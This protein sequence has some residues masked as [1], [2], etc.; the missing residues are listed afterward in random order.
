[1]G[2]FW[3]GVGTLLVGIV[4]GV[5]VV[6]AEDRVKSFFAERPVHAEFYPSAWH[7][8]P[9]SRTSDPV[10]LLSGSGLGRY[11]IEKLT[12]GTDPNF[13]KIEIINRGHK[14]A[15]NLRFQ[16]M[17]QRDDGSPLLPPHLLVVSG[18]TNPTR[19][20]YDEATDVPVPD[21][22]PGASAT[23]YMWR[24][25]DLSSEYLMD[26]FR[27]ISETGVVPTTLHRYDDQESRRYN[28]PGWYKLID[29]G[30]PFLLVGL[31]ILLSVVGI[32]GAA[33]YEAY[34][35]KLLSDDLL[36]LGEKVRYD[37]DPKKFEI[38]TNLLK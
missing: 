12:T 33:L 26:D 9:N 31:L 34:T 13:A 17:D 28:E 29:E 4:I 21:I 10:L 15:T 5:V 7:P 6:A 36:Y 1:M 11:E 19:A 37:A 20:F 22:E 23:L 25:T 8:Y 24:I 38:D 27:I 16:N 2:W 14:V 35:K 32:G 30:I 3:R 18:G